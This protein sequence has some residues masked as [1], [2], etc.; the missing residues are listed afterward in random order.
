[1][2][3]FIII[4]IIFI[5]TCEATLRLNTRST[6]SHR[7]SL[8]RFSRLKKRLR[9]I[10]RSRRHRQRSFIIKLHMNTHVVLH[11]FL[12]LSFTLNYFQKAFPGKFDHSISSQ[13]ACQFFKQ[14]FLPNYTIMKLKSKLMKKSRSKKLIRNL[15][16]KEE[17]LEV[18]LKRK[19][20]LMLNYNVWAASCC[21]PDDTCRWYH[22]VRHATFVV[23]HERANAPDM[24]TLLFTNTTNFHRQIYLRVL[25]TRNENPS[26][27]F[28]RLIVRLVCRRYELLY[29][30][31]LSSRI[32]EHAFL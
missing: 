11:I 10:D 13:N 1:M 8:S 22:V 18:R 20:I 29:I 17:R 15:L 24:V 2:P 27:N 25:I 31:F 19:M 16:F 26:P 28:L 3:R 14:F 23:Y 7:R 9:N 30:S 21:A 32:N 5:S 12:D 6:R 4:F